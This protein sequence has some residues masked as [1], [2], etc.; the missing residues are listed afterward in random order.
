MKKEWTDHLRCPDCA[1]EI[2]CASVEEMRGDRVLVGRLRCAKCAK[3]YPVIGGVPRFVSSD[4]YTE[5]F[6]FEWL[7]HARTQYDEAS[8]TNITV[9][10][11]F[12]ETQWPGELPGEK[13]LE[14]GG[15]SGRFTAIAAKTGAFVVS[16]DFSRAVEANY[17]SNGSRDNVLIVQ[18][19]MY[20]MPFPTGYFDRLYCLGVIQHTPDVERAFKNLPRFL[21][22]GGRIAMDCYVKMRGILP[23]FLRLTSTTYRARSITKRMPHDRLY[24]FCTRYMNFMWPLA[25][26][27]GRSPR[28]GS[29]LLRRLMI[30]PYFGVYDLPEQTLKEWMILDMFDS[31]SPAYDSP[32]FIDVVEKWFR[33]CDLDAIDVAYG[34]NGINGRAVRKNSDSNVPVMTASG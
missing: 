28:A 8:G 34:Y 10:R 12:A 26:I 32:Q 22:P 3:E 13:I 4:N 9:R 18:A 14:V 25:K 30:P 17:A 1:G 19:D 23:F 31:L 7:R 11:F 15:G 29:F 33:D 21:K 20:R 5:S 6:G 16:L 2:G 24:S 27:L